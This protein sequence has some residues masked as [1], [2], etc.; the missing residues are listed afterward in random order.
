MLVAGG[1]IRGG[2]VRGQTDPEGKRL[3]P[4]QGTSIADLHATVLTALGINPAHEE[5][6]A[7]GRPIKLSEGQPLADM[8]S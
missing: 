1:R 3:S 8:L 6:A 4:A 5:M 7:I 2:H